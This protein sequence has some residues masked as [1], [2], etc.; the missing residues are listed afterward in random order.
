MYPT[1]T[2]RSTGNYG[3]FGET[4]EI[5]GGEHICKER[6]IDKQIGEK[7]CPMWKVYQG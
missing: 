7:W 6:A 5:T 2:A 4:N 1:A 3:V